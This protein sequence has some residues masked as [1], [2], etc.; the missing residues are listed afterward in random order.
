MTTESIEYEIKFYPR[1]A[2]G[3]EWKIWPK[4]GGPPADSGVAKDYAE[5]GKKAQRAK[6]RLEAKG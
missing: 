3:C 1:G 5:A 2:G 4:N 6:E